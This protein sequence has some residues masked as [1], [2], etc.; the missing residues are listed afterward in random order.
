VRVVQVDPALRM[1]SAA[2]SDGSLRSL[3]AL[4]GGPLQIVP[5]QPVR[6][7]LRGHH[8]YVSE[9]GRLNPRLAVQRWH[10]RGWHEKYMC[11]PG[12]FL[13]STP[14]GDEAPATVSI[15]DVARLVTWVD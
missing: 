8:L 5:F 10:L 11:G 2:E 13:M 1:V 4:V 15:A 12:I 9:T 3:Q 14:D 7:G 6:R